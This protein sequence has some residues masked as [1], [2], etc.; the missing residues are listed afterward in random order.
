MN[1]RLAELLEKHDAQFYYDNGIWCLYGTSLFGTW[2]TDDYEAGTRE[3]AE[4]EAI[5]YLIAYHEKDA[6]DD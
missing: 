2:E 3:E 6:A 1:P 5:E 4:D